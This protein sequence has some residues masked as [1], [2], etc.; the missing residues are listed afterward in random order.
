MMA[1]EMLEITQT[2]EHQFFCKVDGTFYFIEE[3]YYPGGEIY[4]RLSVFEVSDFEDEFEDIIKGYYSPK[5]GQSA[6]EAL[7]MSYN[8]KLTDSEIEQLIA[9]M[10]SE[11]SYSVEYE[12]IIK[13]F[14]EE[15]TVE[16]IILPNID[17]ER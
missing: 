17:K 11:Q 10:I 16:G 8:N 3:G 1:Q 15:I 9:E 14:S 13:D 7:K 6:L 12:T 5:E 2:D 4:Q